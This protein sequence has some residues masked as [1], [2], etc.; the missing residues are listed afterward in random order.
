M[1]TALL[2]AVLFH[3]TNCWS[4]LVEPRPGEEGDI[5]H[6]LR[7]ICYCA[8]RNCRVPALTATNE[9]EVQEAAANS[10]L[11]DRALAISLDALVSTFKDSLH[12]GNKRALMLW[13]GIMEQTLCQGGICLSERMCPRGIYAMVKA[14]ML[15]HLEERTEEEGFPTCCV[16]FFRWALV[17]A[18]H[19]EE[20]KKE[21]LALVLDETLDR[22]LDLM[23]DYNDTSKKFYF[24]AVELFYDLTNGLV[25]S[26]RYPDDYSRLGNFNLTGDQKVRMVEA[27]EKAKA[28]STEYPWD[29]WDIDYRYMIEQLTESEQNE[30]D[31]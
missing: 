17:C 18:F 4:A 2:F 11:I 22:I 19:D 8:K 12:E 14:C 3:D 20:S 31:A 29:P 10:A 6:V 5:I 16:A 25:G 24:T 13:N 26:S 23:L 27:A 30:E 7:E 21:I 28:Q 9:K 15:S 1:I